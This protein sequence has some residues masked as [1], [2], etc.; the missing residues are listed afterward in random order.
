VA[1]TRI[2]SFTSKLSSTSALKVRSPLISVGSCQAV[3]TKVK[4]LRTTEG[5]HSKLPET[6]KSWKVITWLPSGEQLRLDLGYNN[7]AIG[8][9]G[10]GPL[11][12]ARFRLLSV[13]PDNTAYPPTSAHDSSSKSIALR[14]MRTLSETVSTDQNGVAT[15][16]C[17]FE[18]GLC[19]TLPWGNI[20][21][22]RWRHMQP[23]VKSQKT[24]TTG[25]CPLETKPIHRAKIPGRRQR[26]MYPWPKGRRT[27]TRGI[28]MRQMR[29]PQANVHRRIGRG[30][31]LSLSTRRSTTTCV[32]MTSN[33]CEEAQIG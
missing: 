25:V 13:A 30:E 20:P 21:G 1:E 6:L 26:R 32:P 3:W 15:E 31:K 22:R 7:A 11:G 4:D 28:F 18:C 29:V 9:C 27:Y 23:C 19:I 17:T 12:R 8:V 10:A 5:K 24:L 33:T 14:D 2:S 16:I